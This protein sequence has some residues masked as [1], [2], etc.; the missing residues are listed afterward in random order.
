MNNLSIG[1]GTQVTLY[2][3]LRLEDGS[4]IDS[5]FDAEAA[6]FFV[7]DGNLLPGF[8]EALFGLKA[9]DEKTLIIQPEKGFGVRNPANI[10]ELPRSQFPSDISLEPGLVMTFADAQQMEVPGVV[11]S[12]NQTTVNV[13]FNHPLAGR[14]IEFSVKI[15]DVNPTVTH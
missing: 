13:D 5:N 7:G 11:T 15:M 10:Q 8:E 3:S 14:E 2:F 12:F 6:T 4:V 9:G 1:P